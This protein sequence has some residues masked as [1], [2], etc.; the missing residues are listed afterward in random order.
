ME[1]MME[2][3]SASVDVCFPS[4]GSRISICLADSSQPLRV[5]YPVGKDP[6]HEVELLRGTQ[7]E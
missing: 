5:R 1:M 7:S 6:Q 3:E 4:L 2:Q